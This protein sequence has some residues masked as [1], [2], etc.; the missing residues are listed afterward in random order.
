MSLNNVNL[1]GKIPHFEGNYKA[2]EGD[3]TSFLSWAVSVQRDRKPADAKYY[4]E[5]LINIKAFGGTADFINNYFN[6][7]DGIIISGRIQKDDDYEKDGK[8]MKGGMY[9]LVE[10]ASFPVGK[11]TEGGATEK[12]ATTAPTKPSGKPPIGSAPKKPAPRRPF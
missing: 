10:K 8:Q 11:S 6:K 5:D 9:V 7:G 12:K 2:G 1:N 4:P 3:K